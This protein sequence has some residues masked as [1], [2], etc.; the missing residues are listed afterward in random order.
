MQCSLRELRQRILHFIRGKRTFGTDH[1]SNK[2]QTSYWVVTPSLC[3]SLIRLKISSQNMGT[4]PKQKMYRVN[5][6]IV[7]YYTT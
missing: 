7:L 4:I 1:S 3:F 6:V 5:V 2:L